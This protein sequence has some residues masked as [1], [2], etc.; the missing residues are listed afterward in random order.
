MDACEH[1]FVVSV[2]PEAVQLH[3]NLKLWK[4]S[5]VAA[6]VGNNT[7]GTVFITAVLDFEKGTGA[8]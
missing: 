6:E 8:P 5:A 1:H 3:A 2:G 4:T 7:I